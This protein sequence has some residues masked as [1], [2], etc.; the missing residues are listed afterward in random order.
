MRG[1]VRR[2]PGGCEGAESAQLDSAGVYDVIG[3][4]VQDALNELASNGE[5]EVELF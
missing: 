3:D 5:R 2:H 1:C 4:E